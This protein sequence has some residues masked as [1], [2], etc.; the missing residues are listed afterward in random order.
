MRTWLWYCSEC[1]AYCLTYQILQVEWCQKCN[2]RHHSTRSGILRI[3][4]QPTD[5]IIV[6]VRCICLCYV[7][8]VMRGCGSVPYICHWGV[9]IQS[10]TPQSIL[11]GGAVFAPQITGQKPKGSVV[12]ISQRIHSQLCD[13][14]CMTFEIQGDLQLPCPFHDIIIHTFPWYFYGILSSLV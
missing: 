10:Y 7:S 12:C 6:Q 4:V 13:T 9:I 3:K 5:I 14:H 2:S 8:Y 1:P 11:S